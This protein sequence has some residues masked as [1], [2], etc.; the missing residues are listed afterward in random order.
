MENGAYPMV[1][2]AWLSGQLARAVV[3]GPPEHGPIRPLS[4]ALGTHGSDQANRRSARSG[5]RKAGPVA[6]S[7]EEPPRGYVATT[8]C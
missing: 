2:R 6:P 7:Q 1:D 5:K 3:E 8:H 4:P